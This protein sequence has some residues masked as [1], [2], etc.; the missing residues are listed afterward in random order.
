MI[1]NDWKIKKLQLAL[2]WEI[3][4]QFMLI[5]SCDSSLLTKEQVRSFF[6]NSCA[7]TKTRGHKGI[8]SSFLF[9]FIFSFNLSY[10]TYNLWGWG[11]RIHHRFGSYLSNLAN[12]CLKIQR[13]GYVAMR[14]SWVQSLV[15]KQ[16]TEKH[17]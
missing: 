2:S 6:L 7:E 17:P 8:T 15:P 4:C 3:H 10:I 16:Q 5:V 13:L 12:L 11:K 9:I 14:R 1:F